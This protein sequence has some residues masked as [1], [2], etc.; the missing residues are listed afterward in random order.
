MA[1]TETGP[2]T[3]D[4]FDRPEVTRPGP[5]KRLIQSHSEQLF[6][7]T[8]PIYDRLTDHEL[9]RQQNVALIEHFPA[10][11]EQVLDLGCGTGVGTLAVAKALPAGTRVVGVDLTPTMIDR[12]RA[13]LAQSEL[14]ADRVQFEAGDAGAMRFSDGAFHAV[15]ANSFL[16][17][18]PEPARVLSEIHRVLSPGGRFVTMEPHRDGSLVGA[19]WQA[20][21]HP[22]GWIGKPASAAWLGAA[23][24][25]WR[26]VSGLAGR[27]PVEAQLQLL[28]ETGFEKVY[29]R[30]TLGGLGVH[31]VGEKSG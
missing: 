6:R 2:G 15:M 9:W 27:K 24:T 8:G 28:R 10:K 31:L 18:V 13:Y 12:A 3:T 11:V 22:R 25:S 29:A 16:Y 17:L 21:T 20:L 30:P 4:Q 5:K 1:R 7:V 19:A 26:V 23:M 14:S